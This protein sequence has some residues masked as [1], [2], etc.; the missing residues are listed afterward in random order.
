MIQIVEVGPRDG[1]QNETALIPTDVK[2]A[3]VDALSDT[4]LRHIEVSAFVSPKWVPQVAD[5]ETVFAGIKRNPQVVY[6]ALVPNERGMDRALAAHVEKIAVFTAASETF[7]QKNINT[8]IAGSI[9]RFVPVL[10]RAKNLR[11]RGY[12]STALW[13][14]YEGQVAPDR[15]SVV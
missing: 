5:A 3:F 11:T 8:S 4:G 10:Q 1:L 2:V 14:P 13:C 7:N 15:K 9:K 6:S 12:I